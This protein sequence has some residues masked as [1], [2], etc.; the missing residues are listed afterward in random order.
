MM[1]LHQ[2]HPGVQLNQKK[3]VRDPET[4]QPVFTVSTIIEDQEFS[5]EGK[6]NNFFNIN[7]FVYVQ[8][9]RVK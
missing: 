2:M 5:G 3:G 9:L 7:F 4:K 6:S 8:R 1:L